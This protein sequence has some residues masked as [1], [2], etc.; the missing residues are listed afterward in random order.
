MTASPR[1]IF[2]VGHLERI[3]LGTP[4]PAIVAHVDR[5]LAQ[6]PGHPEL[7]IEFHRGRRTGV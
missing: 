6:L 5:R 3:P 2:R 1:P 7:V 4:Y